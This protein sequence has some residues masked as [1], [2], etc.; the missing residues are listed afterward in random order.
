MKPH[1]F[2]IGPIEATGR[3]A[4]AARDAAIDAA[5]A[6]LDKLAPPTVL[7]GRKATAVLWCDAQGW[8]Y[9]IRAHAIGGPGNLSDGCVHYIGREPRM[10]AEAQVRAH[11][12]QWECVP[13][14]YSADEWLSLPG[15]EETLAGHRR[16][17]RWQD[18]YAQ[19]RAN[20]ADDETARK[21][22]DTAR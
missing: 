2:S 13:G 14:E 18:A 20:G 22:A 7:I 11:F 10:Y 12:A 1:T 21:A 17:A 15:F 6:A 16:W 19:A 9:A 5:G 8:K 4:T 3:N